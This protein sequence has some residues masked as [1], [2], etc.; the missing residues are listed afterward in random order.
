MAVPE[1]RRSRCGPF[2]PLRAAEVAGEGMVG[3][4]G[5]AM[6]EGEK[7]GGGETPAAAHA[8]RTGLEAAPRAAV[9][10]PG[11][12]WRGRGAWVMCVI[13]RGGVRL[14]G[15]ARAGACERRRD[16]VETRRANESRAGQVRARVC[17]PKS[18]THTRALS[19][20]THAALL[21]RPGRG[22][23]TAEA[24]VGPGDGKERR[25]M[26]NGRFFTYQRRDSSTR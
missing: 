26:R 16:A 4:S 20:H 13:D 23:G 10:R 1:N 18:R 15:W 21:T 25:G 22:G 3:M 9:A 7:G 24:V 14:G 6:G 8:S 17:R 19:L 11:V 12:G 2:S 5:V